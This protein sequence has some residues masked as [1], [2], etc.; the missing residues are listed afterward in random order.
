MIDFRLYMITDRKRCAP[1]SLRS[2]VRAACDAGV[3]AVQLR[4]KDLSPE[5]L[6]EHT[7]RLR[8]ITGERGARL[9]VNRSAAME[10]TE[11][12]FLAASTGADGFHFPDS[13]PFPYELRRRFPRLL[14]GVS[15]HSVERAVTAAALG[16]DFITFGPVFDTISKKMTGV[17]RGLDS[18]SRACAAVGIPIFAVGGV[19]VENAPACIAAGAH[20]VAV[21][22]SIM[23]APNVAAAVA[24]FERALGSL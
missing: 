3:R 22:G 2:V 20:G 9:L 1:R 15:A 23:D 5:E 19:T 17:P 4:E 14:V 13:A 18:L 10:M 7:D 16:A 11:E 6:E 24:G 21:I 8:E 12:V